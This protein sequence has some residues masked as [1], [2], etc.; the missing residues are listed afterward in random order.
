[1]YDICLISKVIE[2]GELLVIQQDDLIA[3][4]N[5]MSEAI[6][7]EI[8]K[9][10]K[11][12]E[13]LDIENKNDEIANIL[14]SKYV[15]IRDV[16]YDRARKYTFHLEVAER[17]LLDFVK[18]ISPSTILLM[19]E[20]REEAIENLEWLLANENYC[21]PSLDVR[22]R[23]DYEKFVT[24]MFNLTVDAQQV[25]RMYN[26]PCC[27]NMS[28]ALECNKV[29]FYNP[30]EQ[31]QYK[32]MHILLNSNNKIEEAINGL[33]YSLLCEKEDVSDYTRRCFF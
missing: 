20:N 12:Y 5:L 10:F 24:R 15:M 19:T 31:K 17:N 7:K 28:K 27:K 32:G 18:R 2:L 3:L 1:M 30:R 25:A 14:K 29:Y 16:L 9:F 6:G 13:E 26:V 4:N 23:D 8:M 11:R 33:K 22:T 21:I